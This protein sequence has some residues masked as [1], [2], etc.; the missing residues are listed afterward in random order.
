[1]NSE[2]EQ[3][4]RFDGNATTSGGAKKK[5]AAAAAKKPKPAAKKTVS[6]S[7]AAPA[8]RVLPKRGAAG[9]YVPS[10]P[11]KPK[12]RA[13]RGGSFFEDVRALSVPFS[14][15]L[16]KQGIESLKKKD[17]SSSKSKKPAAKKSSSSQR[18]GS[19]GT[20]CAGGRTW[21][22]S[23]QA[24]PATAVSTQMAALSKRIDNFLSK[25]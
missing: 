7:P 20:G 3:P 22:G 24:A 23:A 15:I 13:T 1:M 10:S 18:G 21:G 11:C 6:S 14:L 5:K 4:P 25:Y 17:G 19:C 12:A 8:R 2:Y 9:T 16:A